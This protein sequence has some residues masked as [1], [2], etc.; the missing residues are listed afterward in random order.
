MKSLLFLIAGV[1]AAAAFVI[2]RRQ[3][4]A[5][6]PAPVE[7]LASKLQSAWADHHTVA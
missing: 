7:E 6:M 2:A 5:S 1:S 3:A 4:N